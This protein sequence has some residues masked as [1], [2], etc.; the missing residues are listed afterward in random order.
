MAAQ[1]G[2]GAHQKFLADAKAKAKAAAERLARKIEQADENTKHLGLEVL[3]AAEIGGMAFAFGW[4]RGYYGEKKLLGLPIE[5][6]V[7]IA[8]H[9]V[10]LY[11]DF[12]AG[13]GKAGEWNRLMARQFHNLGNGALAAWTH[14]MGAQMGAEMKEKKQAAPVVAGGLPA[15]AGYMPSGMLPGTNIAGAL[16][17]A[18]EGYRNMSQEELMRL[19]AL[20]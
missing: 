11:L 7:T 4:V 15:G 12:T 10:G 17:P 19:A 16:P 5:G 3:A 1:M 2:Q 6:W 14:T 9:G 13:A 8:C 20:A 18:H